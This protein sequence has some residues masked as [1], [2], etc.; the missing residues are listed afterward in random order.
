MYREL[1]SGIG[2]IAN[3]ASAATV[4]ASSFGMTLQNPQPLLDRIDF[5]EFDKLREYTSGVASS[6]SQRIPYREPSPELNTNDSDEIIPT[7]S[8]SSSEQSTLLPSLI[9]GRIQRFSNNIDTDS[10]IP[11]DKCINPSEDLARGAFCYTKPTFY[12]L[13]QSGATIVV[14]EN[15]FGTGSS[16]EQAPKALRAAGIKAVIAKSYAF[17]YARNQ[18]NNGLLGIKLEDERFYELAQEDVELEIDVG[19]RVVRCCGE[20]FG[21]MLDPIEEKLLAAG[22]LLKVYNLYGT[23]LFEKL[24]EAAVNSDKTKSAG[25]SMLQEKADSKLEW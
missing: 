13:A 18:A 21:F 6:L 8:D 15:A 5:D 12:S 10:I 24:Q 11:T 17:I 4:A 3:I 14:A 20:T 22:G 7:L 19:N 9:R 1:T 25:N 2:S 23:R 16:R